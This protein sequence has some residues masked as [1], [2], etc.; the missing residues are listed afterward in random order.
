MDKTQKLFGK[1]TKQDWI[2]IRN[3]III[4]P[5]E[6]TNWEKSIVL[7]D[8]R[9]ETRY[10]KPI[11]KILKMRITTGEG[12][13]VMTLACSL[14]EFLQSCHEGKTYEYNAKESKFIY[15]KSADKFKSFLLSHDPFKEFFSKSVSNPTKKI[16]TFADDFYSNVRCGLLHEAATKNNWVIK[17]H[18]LSIS[19]TK[20]IDTTDENYKIIFR[21]NFFE[22]IKTYIDNY[23][24]SLLKDIR[25]NGN[26]LR[27]NF[28]R[29]FDMLCGI[30]D[31]ANWWT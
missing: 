20:F 9:L 14:I 28:A 16:K 2:D 15:G 25:T 30:K 23:K 10:F 6:K 11:Q 24:Q 4:N 17:T 19:T 21:D 22:A 3:D 27:E 26:S 29:K 7:L 31:N 18:Q 13:A 1:K 12:F 5:K 8:E